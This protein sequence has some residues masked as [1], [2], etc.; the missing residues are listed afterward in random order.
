M[1]ES[2][3]ISIFTRN[4]ENYS[5]SPAMIM[6]DSLLALQKISNGEYTIASAENPVALVLE[7]SAAQTAGFLNKNFILNRRQYAISAQTMDDLYYHLNDLDWIGV[8]SLPAK[9]K[10]SIS[11]EYDELINIMAP[12]DDGTG[13]MLKIPKGAIFVIGDINFLLDYPIDIIRYNH[14]GIKITYNTEDISPLH[15]LSTNIID[16]QVATIDGIRRLS[17]TVEVIQCNVTSFSDSITTDVPFNISKEFDNEFIMARVYTGNDTTGWRELQTTHCPDIYDVNVETAVLKVIDNTLHVSIP[18]IY[19][20]S[21]LD[22][23]SSIISSRLGS[24][25]KIDIYTTLGEITI[26]LGKYPYTAFSYNLYPEGVNTRNY[27]L[28]KFSEGLTSL[29]SVYVYSNDFVQGGRNKLSFEE[30]RSR[31]INHT[32]GNNEIPI[33]NIAI[34]TRIQDSHFNVVKAVDY[35]TS[36]EYWATRQLPDP[37]NKELITPA[38]ISIEVLNITISELL[39]T[40]TVKN[41][42]KRITITP[43]SL[44]KQDNGITTMLNKSDIDYL[45]SLSPEAKA[46]KINELSLL[47]TPFHYVVDINDD[48]IELRPYYLDNPICTAKHYLDSNNYIDISLTI[49]EYAITKTDT[50]FKL[51]I[52][53]HSNQE[54]KNIIDDKVF[55]Q[56]L[57]HPYNDKGY[58]YLQGELIGLND[59]NERIFEF[60]INTNLDIDNNDCLILNDMHLANS[61]DTNIPI[62]LDVNFEIILGTHDDLSNWQ[63][64]PLDDKINI[65]ITKEENVKAITYESINCV[66]GNSLKNLWVRAR[67]NVSNYG[68]KR[69]TDDVPLTYTED[70]YAEDTGSIIQIDDNDNITYT[71]LHSK[72]DEVKDNNGNTVYKHRA[73]DYIKDDNGNLIIEEPRKIIRRLE[74]M[75]IDGTYLFANDVIGTEYRTELVN[76]ILDWLIDGLEPINKRVLEQTRIKFYPSSSNGSVKVVY[77]DGLPTYINAHQSFK[78]DLVVTKQVA[79]NQDILDKI[80]ESTIKIIQEELNKLT[81]SSSS[82]AA[83]LVTDYG[84]NVIGM[85]LK[86]LGDNDRIVAFTVLEENKRCTIKKKLVVQADNTLGVMEDII[87]NVLEHDS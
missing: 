62:P 73:G 32:V 46:K 57:V 36:R 60:N 38:S 27:N 40:G 41:N 61:K 68:Y 31:I 47:Y 29:K 9:A 24:R 87:F 34:E 64:I 67:S 5:G 3:N 28:G 54:Y 39:G 78:V 84:I 4:M 63:H 52:I 15:S 14:G 1:S 25:I 30:L 74:L 53:T 33:S 35:V 7:A 43:E 48:E 69:Y 81:V 66:I 44:F 42:D 55:A 21:V 58:A 86:G 20:S 23:S 70:V 26:D 59:K 72:G 80:K 45:N 79:N 37:S 71:K 83:R 16:Y 75:M 76:T 18:K 19:N 85:R 11:I 2:E 12:L 10:L 56:L 49:G 6:R 51:V 17:F 82:I 13:N 8:Y 50:G 22:T 77:N 65:N